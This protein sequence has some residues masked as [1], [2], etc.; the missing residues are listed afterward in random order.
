MKTCKIVVHIPAALLE[1]VRHMAEKDG[2]PV[3]ETIVDMIALGLFDLEECD[4]YE[5]AHYH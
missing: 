2:R 5:N 4:A 3:N 1:R